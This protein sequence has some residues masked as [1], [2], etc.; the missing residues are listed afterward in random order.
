MTTRFAFFAL[1]C[2][3]G[4]LLTFHPTIFSGFQQMQPEAG[5]VLLNNLF[6]E[7]TY[8][9]AFDSHYS[10]SFWSP[11]FYYPTQ[12]TFTYSETLIGTAPLYWLLRGVGFS[13]IVAGQL[14]IIFTCALNFFSLA[15]VL[16]WFGVNT[17]LAAAGAYVF[18]FG[19]M[20]T[21]Q[22]NHQHILPQYFSPFTVWYAWEFLREPSTRRWI[23]LVSLSVLQV[24]ASL[25]LGWFLGLSMM[26][27]V[28]LILCV[29][30]G[31]WRRLREFARSRPIGVVAPLLVGALVVG[32][33]ARNFYRGAPAP[34]EYG[35]ALFY[36]PD[37]DL[38]FVAAPGS[39]WSDRLLLRHPDD[40]AEK[41]L[42]HG[43]T[44]YAA[45]LAAAWYAC[46]RRF[47]M[48]G[49]VIAGLGTAAS[50][51]LLVTQWGWGLSLWYLIYQIVPGANAFR[52]VGRI[53]FEVYLFGLIGGLVGV[54]SLLNERVPRPQTRTLVCGLI[55]GLMILEQVRPYPERFD[56]QQQF[57]DPARSL[58]PR[59]EGVDA[60]YLMYDRSMPDYRHE[61]VMM[62][63]GQWAGVPVLNGFSGAAPPGFP[64]FGVRPT[65]E[66]LVQMLGPQWH[67]RLAVLEWGTQVTRKVYQV[68]AGKDHLRRF[69]RI[70]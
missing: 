20:R 7:H 42:F 65:V 60:A 36:C 19:L 5:D 3:G 24:F 61:I 1:V 52:A 11:G 27:F 12:D 17:V 44:V 6:L 8:R 35:H 45:F 69:S 21:E 48:R 18:A 56:K 54:Q 15:V 34:R 57:L 47:A 38:W 46:R 53:A 58:V 30:V 29:E 59:L 23:L 37:P 43:F 31:S 14:W 25:H 32:M 13:E 40:L 10:Y 64:G 16:R 28:F 70:E 39:V 63:A 55:A 33:Y 66:E 50:L 26:I 41:M 62:W 49:L 67:G 2:L 4:V 68:E 51:M 22:L 9:W